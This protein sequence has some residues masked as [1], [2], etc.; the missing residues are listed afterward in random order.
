VDTTALLAAVPTQLT[1]RSDRRPVTTATEKTIA[2]IWQAILPESEPH[3]DSLF[4]ESGGDSIKAMRFN[5]RI[6]REFGQSIAPR[7]L[8][9]ANL[10]HLAL[11]L[12]PEGDNIEPEQKSAAIGVKAPAEIVEP[13]MFSSGQQMLFGITHKPNADIHEAAVLLCTSIGHEY[14]KLHRLQH[15]VA[16]LLS[17]NGYHVMRFDYTGVGNSSDNSDL[18]SIAD[19]INDI[20]SAASKLLSD[21]KKTKII[22]VGTRLGVPLLLNASIGKVTQVV[23]IDP[24]YDG[25][26]FVD[27]LQNLHQFAL[28]DTD[29]YSRRPSQSMPN[30]RFGYS[31]SETLLQEISALS[32]SAG[33]IPNNVQLDLLHSGLP[34]DNDGSGRNNRTVLSMEAKNPHF[35]PQKLVTHNPIWSDY[36]DAQTLIMD[37]ALAEQIAAVVG[38]YRL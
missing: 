10:E 33:Q 20:R 37:H 14:M 17:A 31:Y 28:N 29:R 21:S 25:S 2:A 4:T 11:S 36:S 1:G 27:H 30:E 24:I 8:L 38:K 34:N 13:V 22:V 9:V 12:V 16:S 15:A 6:Q 18:V 5:A 35:M 7:L 26:V 23:A 19:W 32:I 3:L